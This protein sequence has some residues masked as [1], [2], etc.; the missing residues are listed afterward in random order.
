MYAMLP[1]QSMVFLAVVLTIIM[2]LIGILASFKTSTSES[3]EEADPVL[4]QASLLNKNIA[5]LS[6]SVR[7]LPSRT[8]AESMSTPEAQSSVWNRYSEL[9]A[10]MNNLEATRED[11]LRDLYGN[12]MMTDLKVENLIHE[13]RTQQGNTSS[14]AASAPELDR[15]RQSVMDVSN[16]VD[17]MNSWKSMMDNAD[18]LNKKIRES[19][20]SDAASSTLTFVPKG[21]RDDL[22]TSVPPFVSISTAQSNRTSILRSQDHHELILGQASEPTSYDELGVDAIVDGRPGEYHS[23]AFGPLTGKAPS[24][25]LGTRT[26]VRAGDPEE[27]VIAKM[28]TGGRIRQH[29]ESHVFDVATAPNSVPD[30]TSYYAGAAM[31][32][33]ESDARR[34][35]M[36]RVEK[37]GVHVD[38]HILR[39]TDAGDLLVCERAVPDKCTTVHKA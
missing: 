38:K 21:I 1:S 27:L 20:I 2:A 35:T 33:S 31:K 14:H 39:S 34:K 11:S 13:V 24:A 30:G 37:D 15:L 17:S 29:A 5:A 32:A 18:V 16:N 9:Q 26:G 25:I 8:S 22:M 36:L 28:G 23:F 6:E 3:F 4:Q 7:Q 12:Q 10:R 19:V